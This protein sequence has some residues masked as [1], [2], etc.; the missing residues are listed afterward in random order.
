M[1]ASVPALQMPAKDIPIQAPLELLAPPSKSL[2]F[3]DP[4]LEASQDDR[5]YAWMGTALLV[6]ALLG[7]L[8]VWAHQAVIEQVATGPGRAI[9]AQREQIIQSLEG[10]ILTDVLVREGDLVNPGDPLVQLDPIRA[11]SSYGEGRNK[12]LALKAT[13]ARLQA[14]A[15]DLPAPTFDS[16]VL[17]EKALVDRERSTY[18]ARRQTL[19]QVVS[20]QRR[21]RDL[22]LREIS[23]TEPMVARGL[24][25]EVEL[26]RLKR[27]SSEIEGQIAERIN[28]FRAEASSELVKVM[29]EISQI[30]EVLVA[31]QDLVERTIIRAPIRG[32]VKNIRI[33][34]RGGVVQPGQDILEVVPWG[35]NLLVEAKIRPSDISFMQTGQRATVKISAY[36]PQI[37]GSL[38]GTVEF[39]SPDTLKEEKTQR[40]ETYYKV[41]VRTDTSMLHYKGKE[42]PVLPGMT[43]TVD[44]KT[45]TTT[46]ANSLLKPVL[47]LKEAFREK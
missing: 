2:P 26:L 39:I 23:I 8:G 40:E 15:I 29:G 34:T 37:Y 6:I 19:Q 16:D 44:I 21:T 3:A 25:A 18:Q 11:R 45:G 32:T 42:L 28:R 31:K 24:V 35:D 12:L 30:S 41:I 10:G 22:L 46:V 1:K 9:A 36:D 33:T 13:A 38:E 14:E 47:R 17:A 4:V 43:T 7:S 20:A 27:Q 5:S